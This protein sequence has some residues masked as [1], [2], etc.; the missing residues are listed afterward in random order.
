MFS[1]IILACGS[2]E[3]IRG[4]KILICLAGHVA[5][6]SDAAQQVTPQ[7]NVSGH[8]AAASNA[9]RGNS[10]PI[11]HASASVLHNHSSTP[12]SHA[13]KQSCLVMYIR[14]LDCLHPQL[15][16]QLN[17]RC[18]CRSNEN[19]VS[20][21]GAIPASSSRTPPME[22]RSASEHSVPGGSTASDTRSNPNSNHRASK[23]GSRKG[24]ARLD[25]S[26]F[27]PSRSPVNPSHFFGGRQ[28]TDGHDDQ[29]RHRGHRRRAG[30]RGGR[31]TFK[32]E[33]FLQ[34]SFRFVVSDAV[35][36]AK[37][38]RDADA[39]FDWDDVLEVR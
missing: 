1:R 8:I 15:Q 28:G 6:R 29:P 14:Q 31:L 18:A 17:I 24:G 20:A 34:A 11:R 7:E 21:S 39:M 38:L 4:Q 27:F 3:A 33:H 35:D 22:R 30:G 36:V 5:S 26:E 9:T 37:H 25:A 10:K 23:R 32:K 13:I 19:R 2:F 16:L 12:P